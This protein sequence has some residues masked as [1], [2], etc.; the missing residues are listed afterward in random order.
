MEASD[1]LFFHRMG[2]CRYAGEFGMA[3]VLVA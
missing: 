2:V 3:H 1:G